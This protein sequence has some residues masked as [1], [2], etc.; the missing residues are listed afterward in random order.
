M[1]DCSSCPGSVPKLFNPKLADL[2]LELSSETPL[3]DPTD[4]IGAY[5]LRMQVIT[6]KTS[7]MKIN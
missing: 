5:K 7:A 2:L 3:E 4:H 1:D 6:I